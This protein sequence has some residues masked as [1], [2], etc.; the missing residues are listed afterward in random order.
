MKWVP[1][2][3]LPFCI[4][5]NSYEIITTKI[6]VFLYFEIIFIISPPYF[7]ADEQLGQ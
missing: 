5:L 3:S 2:F 4:R 6:N 7:N 1:L